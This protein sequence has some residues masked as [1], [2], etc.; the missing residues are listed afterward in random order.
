MKFFAIEEAVGIRVAGIEG[1]AQLRNLGIGQCWHRRSS[2][3]AV[4]RSQ[5]KERLPGIM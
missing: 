4:Q 2:G 1:P 3:S 5:N